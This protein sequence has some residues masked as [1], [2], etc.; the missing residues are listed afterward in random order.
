[1]DHYDGNTG[2]SYCIN[3]THTPSYFMWEDEGDITRDK[4]TISDVRKNLSGNTKPRE[5]LIAMTGWA[6]CPTRFLA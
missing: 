4:M 1:M 2:N 3:Q 6:K 5:R